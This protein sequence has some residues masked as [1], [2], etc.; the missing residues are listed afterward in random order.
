M[1]E[2]TFVKTDEN[3][4][5]EP[6]NPY[7]G[8]AVLAKR[9]GVEPVKPSSASIHIIVENNNYDLFEI[10]NAFLDKMDKVLDEHDKL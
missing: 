2:Y 6:P 1:T 5:A 7:A 4:F 8:F 3:C 9:L 10:M